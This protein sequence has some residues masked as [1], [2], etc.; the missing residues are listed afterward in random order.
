MLGLPSVGPGSPGPIR[1]N[2]S[3]LKQPRR[4]PLLLHSP[5]I[6]PRAAQIAHPLVLERFNQHSVVQPGLRGLSAPPRRFRRAPFDNLMTASFNR[7]REERVKYLCLIYQDESKR[8]AMSRDEA[9]SI[10][11]SLLEYR[12]ELRESGHFVASAPPCNEQCATTIRIWNGAMSITDGPATAGAHL[13]GFYVIDAFDLNDAIRVVSR[14]PSA[15]LGCIE[16]RPLTEF[17]H[18]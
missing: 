5:G 13:S 12:D 9:K 1:H 2:S 18:R 4:R 8:N 11:D 15:R 14:M 3:I 17:A 6:Y 16:L 7:I 10:L